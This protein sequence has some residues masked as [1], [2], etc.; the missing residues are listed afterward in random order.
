MQLLPCSSK[1]FPDYVPC[2]TTSTS[3]TYKDTRRF[4][5]STFK[6]G[7]DTAPDWKFQLE[8]QGFNS[9]G[10]G[11]LNGGLVSIQI[12]GKPLKFWK[13]RF[14]YHP[15][16][17]L[18]VV[19]EAIEIENKLGNDPHNAYSMHVD[20]DTILTGTSMTRLWEKFDCARKGKPILVAGE[21]GCLAG[22]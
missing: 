22:K 19:R 1:V 20:Y 12:A 11:G 14:F 2:A 17:S 4:Y 21:T 3:S 7:N 5:L 6:T 9:S 18:Q 13:K 16:S 10:D 15:F 8:G